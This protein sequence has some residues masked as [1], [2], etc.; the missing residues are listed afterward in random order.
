MKKLVFKYYRSSLT[1]AQANVKWTYE[2]QVKSIDDINSEVMAEFFEKKGITDMET[3]R[4]IV[5]ENRSFAEKFVDWL[6]RIIQRI[7]G[8]KE[9]RFLLKVRNQWKKALREAK[10]G[11]KNTP[12]E[13]GV[14]TRKFSLRGKI[15]ENMERTC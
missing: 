15:P 4:S 8:T 13:A 1:E 10:E 3:L 9:Q 5:K 14:A 11:I 12:A 7:T 6:N 2:G